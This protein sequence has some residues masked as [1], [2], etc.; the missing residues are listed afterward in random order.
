VER[1]ARVVAGS[2]RVSSRDLPMAGG[3][4][5]AYM[6]QRRPAAYFFLGTGDEDL[7]TPGCHHPDFDFDD[8]I[9]PT[10]IEM[11]VGLVGDRLS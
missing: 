9:I 3:E 5:F 7:S 8:S 10:G 1:V 11:F 2:D 4:D 6:A